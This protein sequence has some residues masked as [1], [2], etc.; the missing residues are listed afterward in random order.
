MTT[1]LRPDENKIIRALPVIVLCLSLL[2]FWAALLSEATACPLLPGEAELRALTSDSAA[3]VKVAANSTANENKGASAALDFDPVKSISF[4]KSNQAYYVIENQQIGNIL[5]VTGRAKNSSA[6]NISLIRLRVSLLNDGGRALGERFFYAGNVL[7]EDELK[8]LSANQIISRLNTRDGREGQNLNI[9]PGAELPF[10]AVFLNIPKD[11]SEYRFD[12]VSASPAGPPAE[13]EKAKAPTV[14]PENVEKDNS[15]EGITFTRGNQNHYFRE[16][17][18][19]G[20]ILIITGQVRNSFPDKRSFIRLRGHLL[21]A[22]GKTLADRYIY[23]GNVISENDLQELPLREIY[24][25]LSLKGGQDGRNMS[26]EPGAEI[27]FMIVFDKLPEGM[28]EYRI[29]PISSTP[30]GD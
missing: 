6:H 20:N 12:V 21:G 19:A 10:M 3:R 23:A 14:A 13:T 7:S 8:T 25:R 27:P 16:N 29:D 4:A 11:W 17:K 28:S 2:S 15:A 26:I 24:S 5:V 30:A 9:K 1:D 22:D 18:Q